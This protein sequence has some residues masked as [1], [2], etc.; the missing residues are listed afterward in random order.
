MPL[1]TRA[2]RAISKAMS[3]NPPVLRSGLALLRVAVPLGLL[4]LLWHGLDGTRIL[5]TL[6][7]AAPSWLIGAL[8]LIVAQIGLSA[9]RWRL[10]AAQLGQRL[11][12]AEAVAEY[13]L[14]Q[15]VNTTL[16]GGVLG[17]AGRAVR[18]RQQ[19]GLA[20]AGQ[21]VVLERMVGQI[22]FFAILM[23]GLVLLP[24]AGW[25]ES[26]PGWIGWLAV[27]L[28]VGFALLGAGTVLAL[29]GRGPAAR[30]TGP[31]A[32]A[33]FGRDV[34]WRQMTLSLL[35]AVCNLGAFVACARAT[36]TT[37]PALASVTVVPLILAAM[38]L[39]VSV[40]GW[41]LREGAA[42]LLWPLAGADAEAGV[43]ASV[44]F[45]LVAMVAGLPG[46]G[47]P[48]WAGRRRAR[49]AAG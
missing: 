29:K 28:S 34:R 23:F 15:F 39:P 45:G 13:F 47:V 27:V 44:A 12:R 31:A 24:V 10:V 32:Q 4:A 6:S 33:L 17:D 49:R 5:D 48:W 19:A 1:V 2:E 43:A 16:P 36:G 40:G 11:G 9:L 35:I 26:W 38:I 25:R 8:G 30:L 37:L 41:G 46:A 18:T 20:R 21:A 3:R 14:S 42:A 7:R 22:A